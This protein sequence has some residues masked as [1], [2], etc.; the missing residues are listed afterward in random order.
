[1]YQLD[2]KSVRFEIFIQGGELVCAPFGTEQIRD[3]VISFEE[4]SMENADQFG[5]WHISCSYSY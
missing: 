5:W 2:T 3:P 4:F 1:M